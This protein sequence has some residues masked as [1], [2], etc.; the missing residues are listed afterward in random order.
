MHQIIRSAQQFDTLRSMYHSFE[1][2]AR[3][4]KHYGF[5]NP[6]QTIEEYKNQVYEDFWKSIK[7]ID[8]IQDYIKSKNLMEQDFEG[9]GLTAQLAS[10]TIKEEKI[11]GKTTITLENNGHSQYPG[12]LEWLNNYGIDTKLANLFHSSNATISSHEFRKELK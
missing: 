11:D 10:L 6:K 2:K 5:T 8:D 12:V 7:T 1:I 3:T 9:A 4:K